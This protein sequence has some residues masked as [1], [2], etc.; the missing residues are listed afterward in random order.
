MILGM[1]VICASEGFSPLSVGPGLALAALVPT[2]LGEI[3]ALSQL[4]DHGG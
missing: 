2:S 1:I 3:E 4:D